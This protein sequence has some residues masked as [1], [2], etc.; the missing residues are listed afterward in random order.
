MSGFAIDKDEE[1]DHITLSWQPNPES[2]QEEY[3]VG[4]GMGMGIAPVSFYPNRILPFDHLPAAFIG[5]LATSLGGL[6]D[7]TGNSLFWVMPIDGLFG[8]IR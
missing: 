8:H 4:M 5:Y 2:K 1:T 3:K 7:H 6:V